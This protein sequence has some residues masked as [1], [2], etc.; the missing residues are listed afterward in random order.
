MHSV[1]VG[2]VGQTFALAKHNES[3]GKKSRIRRSKEERKAM[4]ET[5]IKKY[6]ES[7]NGNFPSLNLTHKEVGGS[8]Y[9]VREIVRDI[10]QENRVLG[11]A[12]FTLQELTSDHFY[13]HNPLGSI[14]TEPQSVLAASSSKNHLE[15]SNS[16]DTTGKKLCASDGYRSRAEHRE[17]ENGRVVNVSQVDIINEETV[18]ATVV[19]DGYYGGFEHQ[20]VDKKHIT[21]DSQADETDNAIGESTVVSGEPYDGVE[22]QIVNKGQ[23]ING[24]QVDVTNKEF[25]EASIPGVHVNES[26][27]PKQN[28]EELATAA[29]PKAK[30]NPLTE[31]LTVETFPLKPV[32]STK[33]GI[34]VLGEL[35]D[36]SNSPENNIEVLE[37]EGHQ[38]GSELN[39]IEPPKMTS[40]VDEKFEDDVKNH[41]LNNTGED[42]V[43]NLG[44]TL[45]ESTEQSIHQKTFSRESEACTK[46][47]VS[48]HNPTS[49]ASNQNQLVDGA[50][51]SIQD[52]AQPKTMIST[53]TEKSKL[54]EEGL[55]KV[56]KLK[57]DGKISGNSQIRSNATLDRI[58]LE[59]WDGTPKNSAKKETNPLVA[60]FKAIV[61]ALVKLLSE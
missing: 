14:A 55:Q 20:E 4:V 59:S 61:D 13:E 35:S 31:D 8:F 60:M 38:E 57:V 34:E 42:E 48:H 32:A 44:G 28:E 10:I 37:L 19:S 15:E 39:G 9:T 22:N 27:A 30:V 18:E 52:D 24:S 11:P 3:D 1:K 33:D 26:M 56:N 25:N 53:C 45:V 54:S 5:F 47:Q 23:I 16:M 43:K 41:I 46:P 36:S 6:Q 17:V 40:S 58:N 2:W 51:A 12:K 21:E 50:K 7:N 49:E 29:T